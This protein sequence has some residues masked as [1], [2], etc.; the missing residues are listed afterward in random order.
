MLPL[1]FASNRPW[2]PLRP[3]HH[4]FFYFLS[5]LFAMAPCFS[6]CIYLKL[7]HDGYHRFFVESLA[8]LTINMPAGV[9]MARLSGGCTHYTGKAWVIDCF[10]PCFFIFISFLKSQFFILE[11]KKNFLLVRLIT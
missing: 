7:T 8:T 3:K 1:G 11:K 10:C 6:V 2:P 5:G 4:L 9:I